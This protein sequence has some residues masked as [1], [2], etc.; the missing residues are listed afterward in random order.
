MI[1]AQRGWPAAPT[2]PGT[3]VAPG[4]RVPGVLLRWIDGPPD[5]GVRAGIRQLVQAVA[6][7]GGAVGWMEVPPPHEVDAW[8]DGLLGDGA[9]LV[10]AYDGSG[11]LVG[12]GAWRRHGVAPMRQAAEV[13][14]VMTH[15]QARGS[16]VGRAVV[17][18]L[19]GDARAA[20]IEMLTLECRGNNHGAMRVYAAVGFVVTGRR[21]DLI[22]VGDERFDQVLMHL[23]LR[24]GPG[25]LR[26]HGGRGEGPGS[27]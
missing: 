15:P 25:G 13:T 14:K 8:L 24:T 1:F 10:T 20:G 26:R 21:P 19:V 6:A 16:G 12:S 17:E 22:A 5:A 3:G 4:R 18:A 9:R 2:V 7:T 11:V 27:T 23:D